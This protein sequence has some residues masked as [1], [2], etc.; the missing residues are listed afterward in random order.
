MAHLVVLNDAALTNEAELAL[1]MAHELGHAFY[2]EEVQKAIEKKHI[3]FRLYR[4]FQRA[5]E[6]TLTCMLGMKRTLPSRSG[7][8]TRLLSGA[9]SELKA[10]GVVQ[11]FFKR[12]A[13]A[14]KFAPCGTP[15]ETHTSDVWAGVLTN[16]R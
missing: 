15:C 3:R 6:K 9:A 16:F 11:Q 14:D 12:E 10:R 7:S 8:P 2:K 4:D 13:L 1:T 5:L